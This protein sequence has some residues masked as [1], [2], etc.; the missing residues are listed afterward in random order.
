MATRPKNDEKPE[1]EP[2]GPA[3]SEIEVLRGS[4]DPADAVKARELDPTDLGVPMKPGAPHDGPEDAYAEETRGDYSQRTAA[5]E[6][7]SF[8]MRAI[9]EDQRVPGGP[10][11]EAVRQG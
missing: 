8:E 3:P 9:P 2:E 4:D 1:Q 10:T 7:G 5:P 11:V 6:A